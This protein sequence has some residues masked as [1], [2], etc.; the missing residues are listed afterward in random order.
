MNSTPLTPSQQAARDFLQIIPLVM[1][2]LGSDMRQ[3]T[4]LPVPGHFNL[5]YLLAKGP[6]NLSELAEKHSVSAPTMSNTIS[7]LVER[8]WVQRI[9]SQQDRRQISISLTPAGHAVLHAVQTFAENR[10]AEILAPLSPEELGQLIAG[11]AVLRSAFT[12]RNL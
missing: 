3:S 7:T 5:L 8:G 6:H 2:S 9:Q 12:R 11:L 4:E 1:H 10:I